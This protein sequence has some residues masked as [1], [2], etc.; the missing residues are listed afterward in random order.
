[1]SNYAFIQ[2]SLSQLTLLVMWLGPGLVLFIVGYVAFMVFVVYYCIVAD[3][4]T[5]SVANLMTE[6]LPNFI[7]SQLSRVLSPKYIEILNFIG[8]R[9]LMVFY[10]AIV[11]GTWTIVFWFIYPWLTESKH[12]SNNHKIIGYIIFG[13][14]MASW[15]RA[16]TRSPG[17]ITM[18]T[19][20]KFDNYPYD[21]LMFLA[22]RKCPTTGVPRLPRSKFDRFRY[23]QNVARFDHFCGWVNNTIGEENYRDFLAFLAVHTGMCFY[24]AVVLGLLFEGEIKEKKLFEVTFYNIRT[25]EEFKANWHVVAQYL[26]VNKTFEAGAFVLM[27]VMGIVLGLFLGYHAYLVSSGMTTNESDKWNQV[28]SWHKQHLKKFREALKKGLIKP[29]TANSTASPEHV[30]VTDGDVSCTTGIAPLKNDKTQAAPK[31]EEEQYFD[32]GPMPKN[33]YNLG[34]VENWKEVL[35]PRSLRKEALMRCRQRLL[36]RSGQQTDEIP[37]K[38]KSS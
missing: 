10:L 23:H 19:V 11:L 33:I 37:G 38:M 34:V 36:A 22:D 31:N 5:S 9:M 4:S 6:K 3:P 13:L 26:F 28:R 16:S 1:M 30:E 12:V 15:R 20:P 27:L 24:G 25:K 18:D 8:D 32:P 14:C 29:P 21:N 7:S 17:I 2:D 35:F